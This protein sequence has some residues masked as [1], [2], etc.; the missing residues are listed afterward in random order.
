MHPSA[1][2]FIDIGAC[3]HMNSRAERIRRK[4]DRPLIKL[5]INIQLEFMCTPVIMQFLVKLLDFH[6]S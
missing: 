2:P 1:N 3:D 5:G 4:F 6:P